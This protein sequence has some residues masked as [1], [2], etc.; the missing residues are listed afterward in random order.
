MLPVCEQKNLLPDNNS[1]PIDIYL[2]GWVSGH[3]PAALN[4]TATTRLQASLISEA[5]GKCATA[6]VAIED[7]KF[8]QYAEKCADRGIRLISSAFES[9]GGF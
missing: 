2:H 5:A 4:L 7:R 6:L 9:F 8:K 1:R 3:H